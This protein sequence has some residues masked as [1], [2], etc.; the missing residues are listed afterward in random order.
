[1]P[2]WFDRFRAIAIAAPA[3]LARAPLAGVEGSTEG[4]HSGACPRL[5]LVLRSAVER[6]QPV[7]L[8]GTAACDIR[9]APQAVIE[10]IA[11]DGVVVRMLADIGP[12]PRL[13]VGES[14]RLVVLA[15]DGPEVGLVEVLA[16]CEPPLGRPNGRCYRL[17]MPSA[18]EGFHRRGDAR[19]TVPRHMHAH[20]EL[21][22]CGVPGSSEGACAIE[23][24]P[25]ATGRLLD[26]SESGLRVEVAATR[27][28][29][30]PEPIDLTVRFQEP[31]SPLSAA[32]EVMHA[33]AGRRAG[34][35]VLGLRFQAVRGDV[36]GVMRELKARRARRRSFARA[37]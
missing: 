21:F 35:L 4:T 18:I 13:I 7:A 31:I 14:M 32:C 20:V 30:A 8:L 27:M 26:L 3:R 15:P 12:P 5:A 6:T 23:G 29:Q 10:E 2:S 19:V 37:R 9:T 33:L 22:A 25:V 28:I 1:M 11:D 24:G 16:P 36:R 34:E 17:S